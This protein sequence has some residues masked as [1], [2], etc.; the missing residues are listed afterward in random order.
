[1]DLL[2]PHRQ[3]IEDQV[4]ARVTELFSL[5]LNL[6]LYDLTSSYFE[7]KGLAS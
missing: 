5:P 2:H 1:M 3:A 6:V 4:F 7:G